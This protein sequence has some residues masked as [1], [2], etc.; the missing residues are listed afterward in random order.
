M[1]KY[2]YIL[3]AV[4][5][6]AILTAIYFIFFYVN[7]EAEIRSRLDTLVQYCNKTEDESA[8]RKIIKNQ[9]LQNFF[10]DSCNFSVG[11][12]GLK[13]AYTNV[14]AAGEILRLSAFF[15]T[16]NIK[17]SDITVKI[18]SDTATASGNVDFTAELK[19]SKTVNEVR[20]IIFTLKK[21]EKK[22]L[23]SKI[24]INEIFSK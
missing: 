15:K 3:Y 6:I 2:K 22:W 1:V 21:I 18:N 16:I 11:H 23:I 17:L 20:E 10:T 19:E 4:V 8:S 12:G 9:I 14:R 13:G 24:E 5:S 7:D